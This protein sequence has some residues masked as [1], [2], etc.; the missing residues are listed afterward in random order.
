MLRSFDMLRARESAGTVLSADT[1]QALLASASGRYAM[2]WHWHDCMMLLM[3]RVGALDLRHQDRPE[4]AWVSE[5]RFAVV[6]AD[7]AHQTQALRD[8][9]AHLALYITDEALHRIEAEAGS[10]SRVKRRI[11]SSAL[12]GTTP[13]IKT[14]Q[15][16]CQKA[17]SGQSNST[18]RHV[19]A[20]LLVSCLSEIE[21]A[22]PLP[23]ATP[24]GHGVALVLEVKAL[25]AD[26]AAQDVSLDM[27]ADRFG[28]SRRHMTRLF[29]EQT[30]KSIAEFHQSMRIALARRML[31]DTDLPVG[32]IAF[33]V[34]FESG[35]ALSRAVRRAE[36][37]SPSG[38]RRAM[39]HPVK[40]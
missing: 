32:E 18:L 24:R 38:I 19:T 2:P 6:P 39:A 35:S 1:R 9:H 34:G 15:S 29:R 17:S 40:N 30:G 13:E 12:F 25:I 8:T 22:D 7:H 37:D 10:L 21:K 26:Q 33:R 4:G 5:D 16:L 11:R 3:P 23:A 27:L 28:I 14:L 20:A 31:T 36:G